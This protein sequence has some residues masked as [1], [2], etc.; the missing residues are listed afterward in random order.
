M[1]FC[2]DARS[3]FFHSGVGTYTRGVLPELF[4]AGARHEF[5]IFISSQKRI[6][7]FPITA[8][9]I[10]VEIS[11]AD[12]ESE[13]GTNAYA[14]DAD[15]TRM[16]ACFMPFLLSPI[17]IQT[18]L[19]ITLHDVLPA[20]HPEWF[21]AEFANKFSGANIGGALD[22]AHTVLC[23]SQCTADDARRLFPNY[24]G[25]L[26]VAHLG[27]GSA[28]R[29]Q[30]PD[31]IENVIS[32]YELSNNNYILNAGVVEPRKNIDGLL[33][34]FVES[35][36]FQNGLPL[37][38]AGRRGWNVDAVYEYANSRELSGRVRF[39]EYV[40]EAHLPALYAGAAF[41]AYPS[42]YEGFGLP[43]L[44]AMACGAAVVTSRAGAIPEITG[45]DAA[46]LVPP[47]DDA[48][49]RAAMDALFADSQRRAAL[50]EKAKQRAARFTWSATAAAVLDALEHAAQKT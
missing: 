41:F 48:Q 25:K 26:R 18:P 47:G 4:K 12:W 19:V 24:A 23:D 29:P 7:D 11:R 5:K 45:E 15:A 22:A 35:E 36:T 31:E 42:L 39:L 2:I 38:I 6:S 27:V 32:K 34:A 46:L 10:N 1:K 43:V 16:G 50:S 17:C 8:P 37:V 30:N 44:E 13:D 21:P 33:R 20:L 49:L 14:A 28:F 9:N 3:F 40:P